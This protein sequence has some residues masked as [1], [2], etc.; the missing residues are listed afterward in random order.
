MSNKRI[1]WGIVMLLGI[2][3]STIEKEGALWGLLLVVIGGAFGVREMRKEK[4][5]K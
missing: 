3:V 4:E 2:W 1:L 5:K